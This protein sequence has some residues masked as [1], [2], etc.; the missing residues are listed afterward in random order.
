MMGMKST[1]RDGVVRPAKKRTKVLTNSGHI[2]TALVKA[3]CSG[4]H[5]HVVLDSGR[6]KACEEYP[7]KFCEAVITGLKRELEDE[8]WIK[9]LYQEVDDAGHIG[10]LMSMVESLEMLPE[11]EVP[12]NRYKELYEWMEYCDDI[13]GAPLDKEDFSIGEKVGDRARS[14]NRSRSQR[15]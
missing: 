15:W 5:K 7:E 3:Q 13:S 8:S 1:D 6:P 11:E 12:L 2:A 14:H 10:T 4:Q 9:K